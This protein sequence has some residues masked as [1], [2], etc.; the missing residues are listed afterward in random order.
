MTVRARLNRGWGATR[1]LRR[2]GA[3]QTS[4]RVRQLVDGI[5]G[6]VAQSDDLALAQ[7]LAA[8]LLGQMLALSAGLRADAASL[9]PARSGLCWMA[10]HR[11]PGGP[12]RCWLRLRFEDLTVC[13][14]PEGTA[15]APPR[16]QDVEIEVQTTV[17]PWHLH[18]VVQVT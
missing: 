8:P 9:L 14:Y 13:Q 5:E 15:S 7:Y 10:S 3:A 17:T 1:D 2:E 18:R 11:E 6:A 16:T 12:G 4:A